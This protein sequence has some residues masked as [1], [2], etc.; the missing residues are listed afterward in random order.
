MT[1]A[2]VAK[3][4]LGCVQSGRSAQRA[5]GATPTLDGERVLP[6]SRG[7]PA[8]DWWVMVNAEGDLNDEPKQMNAVGVDSGSVIPSHRRPG[9]NGQ[10]SPITVGLVLSHGQP[11]IEIELS[12]ATASLE[13]RAVPSHGQPGIHNSF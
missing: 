3:S 12:P 9:I 7:M 4:C 10:L 6:A 2:G 1:L 11:G 5:R 8:K 13:S